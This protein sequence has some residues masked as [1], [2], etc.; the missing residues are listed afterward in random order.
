MA[1]NVAVSLAPLGVTFWGAAQTVT[2]SMH[3]VEANGLKV[4]LDCGFFQGRR[5]EARRINSHFPF[6]PRF[7]KGY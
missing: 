2:G 7:N 3:L 5:E 4:L 1:S 6:P